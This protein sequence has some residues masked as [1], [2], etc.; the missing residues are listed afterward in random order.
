MTTPT[1]LS[2]SACILDILLPSF[3]KDINVVFQ[4]HEIRD[5]KK[6]I[7]SI[8][9]VWKHKLEVK[10]VYL[11]QAFL[12]FTYITGQKTQNHVIFS[13]HIR[14]N[15]KGWRTKMHV[16]I[17]RL[18]LF[19]CRNLSSFCLFQGMESKYQTIKKANQRLESEVM[20]L[21]SKLDARIRDRQ[22]CLTQVSA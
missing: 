9:T 4:D 7:E 8:K 20:S 10:K 5:L 13:T 19:L 17:W 14:T 22:H 16:R 2:Y 15:G 12:H 11:D 1:F 6:S 21:H 18:F 3:L